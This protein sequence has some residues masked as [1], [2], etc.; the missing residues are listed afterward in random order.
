LDGKCELIADQLN[1][2]QLSPI[3]RDQRAADQPGS[4]QQGST[5]I[6]SRGST[7]INCNSK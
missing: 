2:D 6:N 1:W 7:G 5:G 4:T 3:N